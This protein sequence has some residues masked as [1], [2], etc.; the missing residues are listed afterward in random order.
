MMLEMPD[1]RTYR[2]KVRDGKPH[3]RGVMLWK[4]G[5]RYAHARS[6]VCMW[7]RDMTYTMDDLR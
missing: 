3:G 7:G 4:D 5:T 6:G 1:G 2:G